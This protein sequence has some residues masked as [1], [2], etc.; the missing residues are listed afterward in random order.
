MS[1][2]DRE[3]CVEG[4]YEFLE[5]GHVGAASAQHTDMVK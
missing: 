4:T 2:D 1:F 3:L 5:H